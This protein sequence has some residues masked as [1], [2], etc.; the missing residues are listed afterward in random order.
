MFTGIIQEI[1]KVKSLIK[2]G[3]N[4]TMSISSEKIIKKLEIGS[5]ISING[6]CQTVI[7]L[8]PDY[9]SVDTIEESLQ[10]TNL[11]ELKIGSSVNLEPPLTPSSLLDGH[12]VQGHV[13]CV[14]IINKIAPGAGS[15]VFVISFPEEYKK[16]V[17]EKGSIAIDGISLTVVET[18]SNTFEVAIIPHTLENTI[19]ND[20]KINNKVNLEFD[21][22]AK[23]I[24]RMTQPDKSKITI[25]FLKEHGF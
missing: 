7:E 8:G 11:G 16:Y 25:D 5:S 21:I 17:V 9:F 13:D 6:A 12:L 19:L 24:E 15:T 2:K 20:K 1:G 4:L 10:R 22:I 23:Y 14:G 3:S 18:S